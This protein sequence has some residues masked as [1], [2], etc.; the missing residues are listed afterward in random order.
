MR[1]HMFKLHIVLFPLLLLGKFY[2][3]LKHKITEFLS[4]PF[5][6]VEGPSK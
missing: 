1:H 4:E 5:G 2:E 3:K 6:G